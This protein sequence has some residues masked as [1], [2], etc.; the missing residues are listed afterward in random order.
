MTQKLVLTAYVRNVQYRTEMV[1]KTKRPVPRSHKIHHR[2]NILYVPSCVFQILRQH[3]CSQL[4]TSSAYRLSHDHGVNRGW[5]P[6]ARGLH[7][8]RL[9]FECSSHQNFV[10]CTTNW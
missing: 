1:W 3:G 7:V 9:S 8:A 10:K 2:C 4:V 6:A 5:E